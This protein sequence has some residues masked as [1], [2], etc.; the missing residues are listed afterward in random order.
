[1]SDSLPI[2][3]ADPAFW[4]PEP[5]VLPERPATRWPLPQTDIS[6]AAE[7]YTILQQAPRL[8]EPNW[9][10]VEAVWEGDT[11]ASADTNVSSEGDADG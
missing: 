5:D 7:I 6:I 10:F 1:M 11:I 8:T 9:G 4:P 3:M 2:S